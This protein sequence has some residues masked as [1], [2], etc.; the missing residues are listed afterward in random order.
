MIPWGAERRAGTRGRLRDASRE[1][2]EGKLRL[3]LHDEAMVTEEWLTEEVLINNYSR[4]GG[5]VPPDIGL[6]GRLH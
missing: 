6:R 4:R 3:L 1:S 5:V 2:I